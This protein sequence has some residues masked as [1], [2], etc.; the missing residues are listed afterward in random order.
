LSSIDAWIF[1][2]LVGYDIGSLSIQEVE[3]LR[4]K[5]YQHLAKITKE[6]LFLKVHDAYMQTSIDTPVFPPQ[7]AAGVI[8]LIRNPL[9]VCVSFAH[10]FGHSDYDAVIRVMSDKN[11]Q[12]N[13]LLD[14]RTNKL[15]ERI[16]SWWKHVQSWTDAPNLTVQVIRYEDILQN[17][18]HIFTKSIQALGFNNFDQET[19]K[20]SVE[21]C[22]FNSLKQQEEANGFREK[23]I[24]SPSFFRSGKSGDWRNKLSA[25]Q[26]RLIL[27]EHGRIMAQFGYETNLEESRI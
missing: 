12:F 20:K 21:N 24:N 26:I 25:R 13:G 10:H 14:R 27:K 1:D 17:P 7:A 8:Y 2:K 16:S 6:P 23:C 19:I 18:L 4:P 5:V 22:A 15:P 11:Y 3:N 9:D